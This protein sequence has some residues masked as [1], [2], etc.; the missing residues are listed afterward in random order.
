LRN[1]TISDRQSLKIIIGLLCSPDGDT[2]VCIIILTTKV[3]VTTTHY[4]D[5]NEEIPNPG[6]PVVFANPESRDWWRQTPRI[7]GLQKL[8]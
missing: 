5:Y 4:R 2:C 1:Q 7:L 8:V 6:I 3:K